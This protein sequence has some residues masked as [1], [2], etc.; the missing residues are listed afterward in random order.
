MSGGKFK[1]FAAGPRYNLANFPNMI[2]PKGT[3]LARSKK[4]YEKSVNL[5]KKYF[6]VFLHIRR[7]P[8]GILLLA[9]KCQK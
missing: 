7:K 4:D 6:R 2:K 9:D 5:N 1:D 8:L 3:N